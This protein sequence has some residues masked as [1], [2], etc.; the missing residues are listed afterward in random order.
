MRAKE[1][2]I[3]LPDNVTRIIKNRGLKHGAVAEKA[4][5]SKQQFCDM[6]NGRKIIRPCDAVAIAKALEITMNELFGN[7][8]GEVK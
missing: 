1:C 8:N 7:N 6:M 5:Y 4:G 2:N 3:Q